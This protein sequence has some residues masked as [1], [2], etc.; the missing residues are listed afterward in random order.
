MACGPNRAPGR[1]DV[2][3][4]K[5]APTTTTSAP[6][7]LPGSPRSHRSTPRKVMS[8]PNIGPYLVIRPPSASLVGW[9][10][11]VEAQ[12]DGVQ[13][14][15]PWSPATLAGVRA[16]DRPPGEL[17]PGPADRLGREGERLV[18]HHLQP[19]ELGVVAGQQVERHLRAEPAG[20]HTQPGV[21][22]RVGDPAAH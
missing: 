20:A 11:R 16:R 10:S 17:D 5:G 19:G 9:I 4:S 22:E 14:P 13:G 3:P 18:P 12:A 8:G 6:A 15:Q 21:A 7:M 2:P 1:C